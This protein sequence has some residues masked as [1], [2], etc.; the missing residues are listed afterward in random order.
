M[1]DRVI[2]ASYLLS[3]LSK[4]TN[5]ENTTQFELV[6]YHNSDRVNDS[7]IKRTKYQ[8][9]YITI[10]YTGREFGLKGELLK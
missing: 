2:L 3:P 8:L 10:C 5:L 1:N 4:I 7:L 9:L 6:K